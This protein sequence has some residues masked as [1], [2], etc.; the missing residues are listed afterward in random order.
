[1]I[2]CQSQH[3]QYLE[4]L[5]I[6]SLQFIYFMHICLKN[7]KKTLHTPIFLQPPNNMFLMCISLVEARKEKK[8]KVKEEGPTL[9]TFKVFCLFFFFSF[10]RI[11]MN[12]FTCKQG[13]NMLSPIY[14]EFAFK[15]NT[16]H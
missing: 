8:F 12:D 9:Q 4:Q 11:D 15:Q 16:H 3:K 2:P 7:Y 1:M 13:Q 5:F 6:R 10:F 14:L